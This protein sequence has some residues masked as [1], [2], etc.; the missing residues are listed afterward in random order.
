MFMFT[1][2]FRSVLIV[3]LIATSFSFAFSPSPAVDHS[4]P[5]SHVAKP[6]V[7]HEGSAS[8]ALKP[9]DDL[10]SFTSIVPIHPIFVSV[11]EINHNARDKNLEIACKIFT[12]DLE[13]VLAKATGQ[14]IDL[15]N[16]KDTALTGRQISDYISKHLLLKVDG[17]P[18][19]LSFLGFE[20]EQ[21]AVWSY[22]EVNNVAGVPKNLAIMN[23]LLYDNFKQQINLMHVTVAG[24]RQSTKLDYPE[25]DA[26]FAW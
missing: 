6:A 25:S 12:D 17:K 3:M 4:G 21:D 13:T 26:A 16:P 11:T 1:I 10:R 15:F 9:G 19:T 20:R 14:K 7:G 24:K 23:N 18:V 8:I 22:F 5:A 2:K